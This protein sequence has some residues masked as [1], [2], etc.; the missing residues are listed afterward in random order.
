MV[1][2]YGRKRYPRSGIWNLHEL[3]KCNNITGG[4]GSRAERKCRL[5][6]EHSEGDMLWP[7]AY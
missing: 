7:Y 6:I 5:G 4:L 1:L 2:I 3:T